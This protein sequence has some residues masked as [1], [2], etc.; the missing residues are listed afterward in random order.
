[1]IGTREMG[2]GHTIQAFFG[3]TKGWILQLSTGFQQNLFD[4]FFK[5]VGKAVWGNIPKLGLSYGWQS[6]RL[7]SMR[8][9]V[10]STL[11]KMNDPASQLF[12]KGS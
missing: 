7:V 3:E 5:A 10:W 11:Y 1:M 2:V 12:K 8:E 6:I 4:I 9:E